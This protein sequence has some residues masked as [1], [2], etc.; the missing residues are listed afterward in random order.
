[1]ISSAFSKLAES[2]NKGFRFRGKEPGRL[3]NFSDACFALAI[4]LLLIST[5]PPTTFD[6]IKRFAWELIPFAVCITFIVLI[7]YEHFVFYYRYGVREGTIIVWNS[8]FIILV[9]F[10]VYP[11]KFL[12]TKLTLIPIS[13]IFDVE[14]LKPEAN[15]IR[16]TDVGA[17][18]IIYGLGASA[19]FFVVMFM[20]KSALSRAAEL[21]LNEIEIFD[22]KASIRTNFL[23]AL[24]PL[25]SAFL[26]M[27]FYSNP[28]LA[29]VIP[30]LTYFLYSPVMFINGAKTHKRRKRLVETYLPSEASPASSNAGEPI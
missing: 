12:F 25:L 14:I 13:I 29:G 9:L 26:A 15:A 16:N 11:L 22:T 20:Y 1:M 21:E 17:L 7:W 8:L 6:Q 23:M 28:F 3:E 24:I 10:Y 19:V 18:M 30:G 2:N 5:S 27:I 4:T